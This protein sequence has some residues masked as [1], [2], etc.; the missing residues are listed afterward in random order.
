MI[1]Y[2]VTTVFQADWNNLFDVM[3]QDKQHCFSEISENMAKFGFEDSTVTPADLGPLVR[4]EVIPN[5]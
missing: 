4:V 3:F 2:K 1:T 5:P